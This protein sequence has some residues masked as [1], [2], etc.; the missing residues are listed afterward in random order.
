MTT[1][2]ATPWRHLRDQLRLRLAEN[3]L[4]W[5]VTTAG[6]ASDLAPAEHPDSSAIHRALRVIV[7]A[8][9]AVATRP[10]AGVAWRCPVMVP[11]DLPKPPCRV[12]D[13]AAVIDDG[14]LLIGYQGILAA[15]KAGATHVR[16]KGVAYDVRGWAP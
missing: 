4:H 12:L 11:C 5:S 6:W 15:R 8:V 1:Y 13:V 10:P 7:T 9:A 2:Q 14:R 3:L 16:I